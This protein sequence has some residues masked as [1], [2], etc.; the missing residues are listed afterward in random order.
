[1]CV[2]VCRHTERHTLQN[3]SSV[4]E[5]SSFT[6]HF[7]YITYNHVY[8][9]YILYRVYNMIYNVCIVCDVYYI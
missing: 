9:K 5:F 2:C 1:M 6:F 7:H 3:L 8:M 4:Q